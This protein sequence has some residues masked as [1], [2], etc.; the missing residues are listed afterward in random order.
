MQGTQREDLV[1]GYKQWYTL[2]I[3]ILL[4]YYSSSNWIEFSYVPVLSYRAQT[5]AAGRINIR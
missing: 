2:K 5:G 1:K 3:T 4:K